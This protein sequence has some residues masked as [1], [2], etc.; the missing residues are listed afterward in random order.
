MSLPRTPAKTTS[1]G[2]S[3][4]LPPDPK[5]P[6]KSK[7]PPIPSAPD[8]D[9]SK[10]LPQSFYDTVIGSGTKKRA[11]SLSKIKELLE[12]VKLNC[13]DNNIL[14][15]PAIFASEVAHH[16]QL[17]PITHQTLIDHIKENPLQIFSFSKDKLCADKKLKEDSF[18]FW[19]DQ[20]WYR[21][22]QLS[23]PLFEIATKYMQLST[24]EVDQLLNKFTKDLRNF[25]Q[26]FL[27]Y[28]EK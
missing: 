17:D 18:M 13:K 11:Y 26:T 16:F 7:S 21:K 10:M 4:T 19:A 15:L 9:P 24:T 23:I 22:H 28:R 1:L 6:D 25:P 2:A 14:P 5:P 20:L 3:P 12:Q 27:T 8:L